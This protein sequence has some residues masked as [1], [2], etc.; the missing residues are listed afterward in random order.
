MSKYYLFLPNEL[1]N[2]AGCPLVDKMRNN[3]D[4]TQSGFAT[5]S[6][7]SVG[8]YSF[9]LSTV[10]IYSIYYIYTHAHIISQ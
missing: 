9:M 7:K 8:V 5:F 6:D 1:I 2:S 10:C 4:K 3:K